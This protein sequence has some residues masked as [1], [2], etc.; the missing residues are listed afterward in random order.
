MST[1][2]SSNKARMAA[3]RQA[4]DTDPIMAIDTPQTPAPSAPPVDEPK[5]PKWDDA[6]RRYTFHLPNDLVA[7]A[8]SAAAD[9]G[10]LARPNSRLASRAS[11]A[12]NGSATLATN[13]DN[14][15][16]A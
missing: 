16:T 1:P 9:N 2:R 13:A 14:C 8:K 10:R 12:P 15:S 4:V 11:A 5:R 7:E 3:K 6:H